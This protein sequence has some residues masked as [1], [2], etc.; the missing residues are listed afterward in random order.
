[1]HLKKFLFHLVKTVTKSRSKSYQ[2]VKSYKIFVKTL[3][4]VA[5]NIRKFLLIDF[6]FGIYYSKIELIYKI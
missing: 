5:S 1:M 2:I 4:I 6:V 3:K